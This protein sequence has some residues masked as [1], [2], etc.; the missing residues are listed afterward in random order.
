MTQIVPIRFSSA[1][2]PMR[3]SLI[4]TSFQP[5]Q[6]QLQQVQQIQPIQF[7]VYGEQAL[8]QAVTARE[9]GEGIPVT[10]YSRG[11]YNQHSVFSDEIERPAAK[12]AE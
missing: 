12:I 5:I 2:A 10:R 11:L 4:H 1:P 8:G 6:Q 7:P 3:T 9:T